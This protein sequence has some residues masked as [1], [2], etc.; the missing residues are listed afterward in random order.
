MILQ[1]RLASSLPAFLV[2]LGMAGSA[3]AFCRTRTCEFS[4]TE[5]CL[6]DA[7]G[8]STVGVPATWGSGCIPF[9]IQRDG[10]V[11]QSISSAEIGR[12]VRNGFEAWSEAD[13]GG[14]RTPELNGVDRGDIACNEVEFNCEEPELNNNIILFRDDPSDLPSQTIALS[15]I[16]AN[17]RTGEILDVDIELN[18]NDYKFDG[19]G[20]EPTDL[21]VVVNHELGHLLGLSHSRNPDSLMRVAYGA[22][23]GLGE[24]DE[25]G[26]CA[27]YPSSASDPECREITVLEPE[28]E[29]AGDITSCSAAVTTVEASGCSVGVASWSSSS[30]ASSTE[31]HFAWFALWSLLASAGLRRRKIL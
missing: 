10:S 5:D 4:N 11:D 7:A 22:E 30:Q 28:A 2:V 15:T 17:L 29:C 26:I 16:I 23:F 8:C 20:D 9:A 27:S 24:D 18:S 14:G 12:L 31:N 1:A 13:C 3:Q 21:E 25:A 19:S 6:Y